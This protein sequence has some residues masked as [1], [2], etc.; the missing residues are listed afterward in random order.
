MLWRI[1]HWLTVDKLFGIYSFWCVYFDIT[2]TLEKQGWRGASRDTMRVCRN[3]GSLALTW[4]FGILVKL[5]RFFTFFFK[6]LFKLLMPWL[7][8]SPL[9][10]MNRRNL[11]LIRPFMGTAR[12]ASPARR[13]PRAALSSPIKLLPIRSPR[14]N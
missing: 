6:I 5:V 7:S 8:L 11:H 12:F 4:N 3:F 14:G 2:L 13:R 9:A 1:L 10:R